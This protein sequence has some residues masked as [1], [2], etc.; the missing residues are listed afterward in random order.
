ML[1]GC[2]HQKKDCLYTS[3]L[4]HLFLNDIVMWLSCFP[5]VDTKG[6]VGQLNAENLTFL[7]SQRLREGRR[8]E[9]LYAMDN[10][11]TVDQQPCTLLRWPGFLHLARPILHLWLCLPNSPN[12]RCLQPFSLLYGIS[13]F[14]SLLNYN[15]W[16]SHPLTISPQWGTWSQILPFK[17]AN[18]L[19]YS[20]NYTKKR[21]EHF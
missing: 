9:A 12:L 19:I 17:C 6:R 7:L 18:E 2:I 5:S 15:D 16:L 10:I 13:V 1:W 21:Q 8:E 4:L 3:A 20:N 11:L 14:S